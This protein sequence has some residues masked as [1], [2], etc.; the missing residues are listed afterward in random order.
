M[1]LVPLIKEKKE[2]KISTMREQV[3]KIFVFEDGE[4]VFL[5]VLMR[6]MVMHVVRNQFFFSPCC[7]VV[8]LGGFWK[9]GTDG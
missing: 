6:R 7:S 2:M 4:K 1:N 5:N 9:R 8:L 3:R